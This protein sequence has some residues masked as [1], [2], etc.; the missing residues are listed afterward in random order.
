MISIQCLFWKTR[1]VTKILSWTLLICRPFSQKYIF[2]TCDLILPWFQP[3]NEP[4]KERIQNAGGSV[5][6][7]R[8]NGSLAVSRSVLTKIWFLLF[9]PL[10]FY[11]YESPFSFPIIIWQGS[12]RF[13]VQECGREGADRT[14]GVP[15]TRVLY[16]GKK[17]KTLFSDSHQPWDHSS[18]FYIIKVKSRNQLF[19]LLISLPIYHWT[20]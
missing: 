15:W 3:S 9:F 12:G 14:V 11:E 18:G 5:M 7:Q 4:E 19:W 16:Q 17:T 6:I 10:S 13:W 2:Y 20:S 8:V 1:Q